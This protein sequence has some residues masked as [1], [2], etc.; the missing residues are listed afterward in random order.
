MRV[1]EDETDARVVVA[2]GETAEVE[3]VFHPDGKIVAGD[4]VGVARFFEM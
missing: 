3:I 1:I 2:G 4:V